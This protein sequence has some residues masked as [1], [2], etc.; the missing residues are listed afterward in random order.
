MDKNNN[1]KY[2]KPYADE[3]FALSP[4]TRKVI[5]WIGKE[6]KVLEFACHTG[7]LA[8][9]LIKN[10]CQIVGIEINQEA[11]KNAKPFL[12]QSI[13]ADLDEPSFWEHLT[14]LKFDVITFLHILEHLKFPE[15][16][17]NKSVEFLKEDGVVIIGLPNISNAK[18]RMD[19]LRGEFNYTEM[20]VMDQTHLHFYNRITAEKVIKNAGLEIIDYYSPWQINPL[21]YFFKNL[22][23]FWRFAKWVNEAR[24]PRVF[25]FSANLTDV[26]MLFLC[27]KA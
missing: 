3:G 8:S 16:L 21:H 13:L 4:E 2:H 19:F 1:L 12:Y 25:N 5:E 17:L 20:G 22:P 14:N 26:A 7:H 9:W 6:K 24:P 23:F 15:G 27:K 18:E 10:E 11:L